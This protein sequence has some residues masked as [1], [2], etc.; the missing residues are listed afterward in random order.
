MRKIFI[1]LLRTPHAPVHWGTI[2]GGTKGKEFRVTHSPADA[3]HLPTSESANAELELA[4]DAAIVRFARDGFEQT[5]LETIAAESGMSKRMIHYHFGDKKGLYERAVKRAVARI[6]P[7][8]EVL[9]RSYAVPVEGMRRFVDSIFHVFLESPDCIRLILRENLD[10]ILDVE[11][12]TTGDRSNDITLHVE[13]LLLL[14]QDAGAFRPGICAEDV[15]ALVVGL[16]DLRITHA[17]TSYAMSR[18]DFASQRNTEGMRRMVIDAVL[19]FLTSNIPH[20]GYD[21]YLASNPE[22][23]TANSAAAKTYEVTRSE[24][25]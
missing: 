11:E 1:F 13:R 10:P 7:P 12:L 20:S 17:S 18:I 25:Y 6:A 2:V 3:A 23:D 15:L 24:I 9:D 5:K 4:V 16:C 21:S 8:H 14:G 19:A 22:R